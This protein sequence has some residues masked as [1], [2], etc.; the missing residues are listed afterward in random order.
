MAQAPVLVPHVDAIV[1][2]GTPKATRLSTLQATSFLM[3]TQLA[4]RVLV[5]APDQDLRVRLRSEMAKL[6]RG[7]RRHIAL[8]DT[9]GTLLKR[10]KTYMSP[11]F[12]DLQPGIENSWRVS[13]LYEDVGN[14]LYFLAVA[15]RHRSPVFGRELFEMQ[16]ALYGLWPVAGSFSAEAQFRFAGLLGIAASYAPRA[17]PSLAA[18]SSASAPLDVVLEEMLESAEW[19]A[20]LQKSGRRGFVGQPGLLLRSIRTRARHLLQRRGVRRGLRL[21]EGAA[22]FAVASQAGVPPPPSLLRGL[23]QRSGFAPPFL[24]SWSSLQDVVGA[25]F[26]SNGRELGWT[27][28]FKTQNPFELEPEMAYLS[29]AFT[30]VDRW[31]GGVGRW[32]ESEFFPIPF[33]GRYS[34]ETMRKA[35]LKWLDQD[36]I[37]RLDLQC[38]A[39]MAGRLSKVARRFA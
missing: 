29:S 24:S 16:K 30:Y 35:G 27:S 13:K 38:Q 25:T 17:S 18:R 5:A 12:E 23:G 32:P 20:V 15:S 37:D 14:G 36:E 1:H 34:E 2:D 26:R 9:H 39:V 11:I 3:A 19:D 33:G 28:A 6:P 4:D 22:G 10:T 21:A 8:V 7:Q 31:P